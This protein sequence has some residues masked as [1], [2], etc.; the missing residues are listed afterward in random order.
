MEA[1]VIHNGK[2]YWVTYTIQRENL[3]RHFTHDE[4]PFGEVRTTLSVTDYQV[5]DA[6]DDLVTTSFD[7]HELVT[8][9]NEQYNA[10]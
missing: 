7:P 9:F 10:Q 8:M 4:E 3:G 1:E 6:N 2:T 5:T